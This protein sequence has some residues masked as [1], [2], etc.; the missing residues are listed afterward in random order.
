MY[1]AASISGVGG[2]LIV[3]Y[4]Y[5]ADESTDLDMELGR[6]TAIDRLARSTPPRSMAPEALAREH[7]RIGAITDHGATLGI[8]GQALGD[9]IYLVERDRRWFSPAY[10]HGIVSPFLSPAV[11]AASFALTGAE[12]RRWA[13]HHGLL[14]RLVPEWQGVPFVKGAAPGQSTA[15]T[16]WDGDGVQTMCDL[17]DTVG[18]PLT[19]LIRP[20]A[21]RTALK[22]CVDGADPG[23]RNGAALRQFTYLAV[24][25]QSL[26]P[27]EV[28]STP[29][30][31]YARLTAP[32]KPKT[33]KP[34]PPPPSLI[35][36]VGR[37]MRFIRRT[38]L[39]RRVWSAVGRRVR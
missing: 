32:P 15:T 37:R 14:D 34:P 16:V 11:V 33:P 5:P 4:W 19:E 7:E 28:R 22:N 30:T 38:A 23:K 21:I 3:A 13:L 6:Q 1:R 10:M 29:P 20:Q 24:A 18:G 17:L 39:G 2:E 35:R 25:T 8:R 9:Y 12:K 26:L 27:D 36:K 31:T